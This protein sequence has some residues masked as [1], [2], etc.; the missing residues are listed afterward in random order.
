MNGGGALPPDLNWP[1][2]AD[3]TATT[4]VYMPKRTLR[5]FLRKAIDHGLPPHTQAAAVHNATRKDQHVNAGTAATLAHQVATSDATGPAIVLIGEVLR[6]LLEATRE[7]AAEAQ[8]EPPDGHSEEGFKP[9]GLQANLC[10]SSGTEAC[11]SRSAVQL[12]TLVRCTISRDALFC[13]RPTRAAYD[14]P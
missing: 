14:E 12:C 5:A 2:I 9:N 13:S 11:C 3:P 10:R 7:G 6:P 1:A 8:G 4:A